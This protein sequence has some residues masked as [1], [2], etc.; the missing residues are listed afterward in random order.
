M[1]SIGVIDLNKV[2]FKQRADRWI[3]FSLLLLGATFFVAPAASAQLR[4][5]VVKVDITPSDSQYLLG[6]Q[7]RKSTGV[8]DK[9]YH[10]I[11]AIDDGTTQ[12]FIVSSDL[13]L[14]SPSEYD[15][16]AARLQKQ[17]GINPLNI[18]WS[19]T[20]THSAP[21]VGVTG[22]YGIYMG[23]RIKHEVDAAYTAMVEQKLVDGILEARKNLVPARLGVGWG[24]SQANINRRAIDVNGKAS[25]GLN[26]DGPVDRRIGLLR[27]DKEDGSPLVLIANYAMHGTVMSGANLD[28]SGD[29]PGIV[30]EYVEKK[31]GAP[32]LYIN[33]AAGNLA[34]IY[35]TYPNWRAGHLSQFR[36]LLGDKILEANAKIKSGIDN[37]K[38][39]TGALT[40]ETPRK[41]GMDWSADLAK[42]SVTRAGVN[43]VKLPV[44][45]LKI[46]EEI[47][48]WS[49]PIELFCE[50]SNEV[51]NRSP[52]SYTFYFGYTNGWFGYMPTASEWPH[53]GYEVETVSPFTDAAAKDLTESVVGYLH[54]DMKTNPSP[55]KSKRKK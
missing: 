2:S 29:A 9:I 54:G 24:F 30:A 20:H 47:A 52:F 33:G 11:V 26:P 15:K 22:L 50:V 6:Y 5:A 27:L 23:D 48:I 17:Y 21:E 25:L 35:S 43:M 13:C 36:V 28:I 49:A 31:I 3:S 16:V 51:R 7:E 34:P 41:P 19:T 55:V 12:F 8:L 42:Y 10:R 1:K 18:W 32:V 40:V 46:N 14:Y 39:V 53:G 38:M 4:A 44:R 37:L 45:F